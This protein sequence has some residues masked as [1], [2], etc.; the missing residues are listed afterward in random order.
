MIDCSLVEL[1]CQLAVSVSGGYMKRRNPST[2]LAPIPLCVAHKHRNSSERKKKKS[3]I[4]FPR[5]LA[6]PGVLRSFSSDRGVAAEPRR[7]AS[8]L[9]RVSVC[10]VSECLCQGGGGVAAGGDESVWELEVEMWAQ[11]PRDRGRVWSQSPRVKAR[12]HKVPI[13]TRRR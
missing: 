2:P 1:P 4:F 3:G 12:K 9:H 13:S 6:T 11:E 10:I 5:I 8:S 7:G